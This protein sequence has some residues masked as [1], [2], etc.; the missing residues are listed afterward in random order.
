MSEQNVM[1]KIIAAANANPAFLQGLLIS[2]IE[3]CGKVD[4][5]LNES[6]AKLLREAVVS[7]QRYLGE[8]L[9]LLAYPA[10]VQHE[11][12]IICNTHTGK[13]CGVHVVCPI[14]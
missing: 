13:S 12:A 6:E 3:A 7:T 1:L 8:R 9:L 10:D 14:T 4:I 2:P 5:A 11:H